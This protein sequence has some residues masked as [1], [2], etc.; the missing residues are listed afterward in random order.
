METTKSTPAT[1]ELERQNRHKNHPIAITNADGREVW[2]EW[3]GDKLVLKGDADLDEAAT[4]L[5]TEMAGRLDTYVATQRLEAQAEAYMAV[6]DH[7]DDGA[8]DAYA[9]RWFIEARLVAIRAAITALGE[10]L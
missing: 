4:H 8:N 6:I 2:L 1:D 9:A 5:F 10:K 7:L 3:Q